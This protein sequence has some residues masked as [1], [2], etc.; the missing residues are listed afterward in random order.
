MS[1]NRSRRAYLATLAV[2]A[3]A[4]LASAA[5]LA[6]PG[7]YG[8]AEL[9]PAMRGQDV[10]TLLTLPALLV[11]A[12]LARRGSARGLVLWLG[13]VGYQFYTYTGAA[14]AY[15][16]NALFLVYVAL[17]ALSAF[18]FGAVVTGVDMPT[19]HARAGAGTP[20][21]GVAVFLFA[22][23]AM[24]LV[25]ELAQ[26]LPALI[27]G[28]VPDLITRSEGAG[29]FVYVLDLGVVTPL[30]VIAAVGL[31]RE[32]AWAELLAGCLVVKAAT[33]GLA[34][35]AMT[36]FSLRAGQPLET[37]LTVAYGV[38]AVA[39]VAMTIWLLRHLHDASDGGAQT[40][41][42]AS[43]PAHGLR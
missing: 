31:L 6:I 37:G 17:F 22:I 3:L 33:M 19:L 43:R 7:L 27:D 12:A 36:W 41:R 42:V 9:A 39:G 29:N 5:G 26:I 30:A 8:E 34:L 2:I 38:M 1:A 32:R 20:R 16:F 13:L 24:L 11:A 21:R 23:A 40:L 18:A 25:S 15:R 10:L 14:F 4:G 35:L 28:T